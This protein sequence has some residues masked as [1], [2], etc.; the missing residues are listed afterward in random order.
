M[1]LFDSK[2]SDLIGR[3]EIKAT[4]EQE[5]DQPGAKIVFLTGDGGIGKTC[6]LNHL[7]GWVKE[8]PSEK[9]FLVGNGLVDLY[10]F[11]N[12]DSERLMKVLAE[13]IPLGEPALI[14]YRNGLDDLVTARLAGKTEQAARKLEDT[15]DAFIRGLSEISKD[16][17]VVLLLDTAEK[18]I[19]STDVGQIGEETWQVASAWKWLKVMAGTLDNALIVISGREKIEVLE[20]DA[21]QSG[22]EAIPKTLDPF[23]LEDTR[24][25]VNY[26]TQ[27][28]NITEFAENEIEILHNWSQ[29]LP[30][31]LAM[32]LEYYMYGKDSLLPSELHDGDSSFE[33]KIIA[34]YM[35]RGDLRDI[36]PAL[37]RAPK[38][39]DEK[40]LAHL[41]PISIPEARHRLIEF[42]K[43]AFAKP[44]VLQGDRER[45]F[46]HDVLYEMLERQVLQG[47]PIGRDYARE[48]IDK[49]YDQEIKICNTELRRIF[50]QAM[51][52][53]QPEE[54]D[55]D[56]LIGWSAYRHTLYAERIYYELRRDL[57]N[58]QKVF[59]SYM[60][61]AVW[62]HAPEGVVLLQAEMANYL[63]SKKSPEKPEPLDDQHAFLE[64]LLQLIPVQKALSE[65]DYSAA[66]AAE[67]IESLK[68]RIENQPE[69]TSESR[70]VLLAIMSTWQGF[71]KNRVKELGDAEILL[72]TALKSLQQIP[73]F[74]DWLEWHKDFA[75]GLIYKYLGF[76]YSGQ[77]R[78]IEALR[79]YQE[80]LKFS[81]RT[82]LLIEE[83]TIRNDMGFVLGEQGDF[84]EAL[85]NVED[86]YQ[87]RRSVLG[88]GRYIGLSVNTQAIIAIREGRYREAVEYAKKSLSLFNV[89]GD[90]LGKGLASVALAEA[91]RRLAGSPHTL[92][93]AERVDRLQIAER[94]AKSA[95]EIFKND[96]NQSRLPGAYLEIG[97]ASRDLIRRQR[98]LS[99]THRNQLYRK[100]FSALQEAARIAEENHQEYR[101]V[102]SVTNLAWLAFF[103]DRRDDEID[104]AIIQAESKFP[105]DYKWSKDAG[106]PH[107]D[108]REANSL[109]WS[110]LGKLHILKGIVAFQR[111][112]TN[113]PNGNLM[114]AAEGFMLGL[115]YSSLFEKDHWGIRRAKRDIYSVLKTLNETELA[116]FTHAVSATE[117]INNV[118]ESLMREFMRYRGIWVE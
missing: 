67:R 110:Q 89:L 84:F 112:I 45:M 10:H 114:D 20:K 4:F 113:E 57:L 14:D 65:R 12:H 66:I 46:L 69:I 9:F 61:E 50:D 80:A 26:I 56:S 59:G 23:E 25:Y 2:A 22:L 47:D 86:A 60:H 70:A 109:I 40:L 72:L 117:D 111:W 13:D 107:V 24:D 98:N 64:T 96:K 77:G 79:N 48:Q 28:S 33:E 6:V 30:I 5:L 103:A 87:I 35:M 71:I 17:K 73:A 78:Y 36:L 41:L 21:K 51:V 95:E 19:Y 90:T 1:T 16:R 81:R 108:P 92:T 82:D 38:G 102:D 116:Q 52:A 58:G 18:W 68:T 74:P 93:Q 37:G 42:R 43:F 31:L 49:Y 97:C 32:Y 63:A 115:Q 104:E 15:K 3:S 55:L 53:S 34:M 85:E 44:H 76:L 39:V 83:A 99:D 100:S 62:S 29:G 88:L 7:G 118:T 75:F 101:L 94:Y 91:Y 105:S 106:K 54:I 11:Y 27:K 8:R